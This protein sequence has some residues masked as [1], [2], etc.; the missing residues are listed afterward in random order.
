MSLEKVSSSLHTRQER[1]TLTSPAELTI[2]IFRPNVIIEVLISGNFVFPCLI[3]QIVFIRMV[4]IF[5]LMKNSLLHYYIS[6]FLLL[7]KYDKTELP[8]QSIYLCYF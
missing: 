6:L 2:L 1:G 4:K 8:S 5:K 3:N 7:L